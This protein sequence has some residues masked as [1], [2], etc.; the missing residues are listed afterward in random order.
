MQQLQDNLKIGI[1]GLGL[2]GGSIYKCLVE[3][4]FKNIF[5][6]TS[7]SETIA[8]VRSEGFVA[9]VGI[10][11]LQD[12]DVVFVC[13]PISETFNMVT[14]VFEIN[15][16]AI[17]VDVASLKLDIL[18]NV[19]ALEGCKF[20][21]SHPMA[22]TEHVGFK[23]SFAELFV[24]AKWVLTPSNHVGSDEIELIKKLIKICGANS[25]IMNAQE[26]D[27]AVAMIS[28]AP[29]LIA[30]GLMGATKEND[31]ALKLAASGFR[32]MT[33]LALSNKIMAQDMLTLNKNNIKN[34]LEKVVGEA[35]KLLQSDYFNE[36][37]DKIVDVR[38]KLYNEAGKNIR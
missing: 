36:N 8:H 29:M 21:G 4:E 6:N 35:Q 18:N 7:N 28:H 10:K 22:G 34:A 16:S 26:H 37:I 30:Q 23:N 38:K 14:R 2:I 17:I 15:P 33:R 32:D 27:E 1:I 11:V 12:C 3:Q 24:G 13:S 19:N 9:E 31:V 25:L 5:V 20:I